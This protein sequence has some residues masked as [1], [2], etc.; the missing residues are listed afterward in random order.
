[1]AKA[2]I[3]WGSVLAALILSLVY[4]LLSRLLLSGAIALPGLWLWAGAPGLALVFALRTALQLCSVLI[5]GA[6]LMSWLQR[7]SAIEAMLSRLVNPLLAPLRR[8]VPPIGGL[9]LTPMLLLLVLQVGVML[10]Q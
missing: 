7:G 8:A 3:D 6:V 10:L 1:M 9:D 2:R 5:I 4:A